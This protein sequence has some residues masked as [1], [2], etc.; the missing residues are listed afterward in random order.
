M[1]SRFYTL[2]GVAALAAPSAFGQMVDDRMGNPHSDL[3][4]VHTDRPGLIPSPYTVAQGKFQVEVGGLNGQFDSDRDL[5]QFNFPTTLRYGLTPGLE[6][7]VQSDV[8]NFLKLN[9]N[10]GTPRTENGFADVTAGVKYSIPAG[11]NINF[12]VM[13]TITIPT[14]D[15][16]DNVET[17]FPLGNNYDDILS[18]EDLAYNLDAIAAFQLGTSAIQLTTRLGVSATKEF[19]DVLTGLDPT[20]FPASDGEKYRATGRFAARL[21]TVEN[22][23]GQLFAEVGYNPYTFSKLDLGAAYAGGGFKFMLLPN[24]AFDASGLAGFGEKLYDFGFSAGV[25]TRF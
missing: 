1:N 23:R 8:Y 11:S 10:T 12:V 5:S 21:A 24:L 22:R 17:L 7:R 18:V 3:R 20:G 15:K 13:P 2:L 6:I 9:D 19:N 14:G 4:T 16:I 25:S